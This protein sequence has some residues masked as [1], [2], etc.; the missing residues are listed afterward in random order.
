MKNTSLLSQ[1][2]ELLGAGGTMKGKE[3]IY[4]YQGL[5]VRNNYL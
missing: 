5:F 1:G 3:S 4:T 2:R